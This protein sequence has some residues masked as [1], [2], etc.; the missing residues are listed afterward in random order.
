MANNRATTPKNRSLVSR[1][2]RF[3]APKDKSAAKAKVIRMPPQDAKPTKANAAMHPVVVSEEIFCA[4][5]LQAAAFYA[6]EN[7]LIFNMEI[8]VPCRMSTSF[9]L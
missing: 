1:A 9:I 4:E 8:A 6:D 2:A 3:G 5:K 7:V